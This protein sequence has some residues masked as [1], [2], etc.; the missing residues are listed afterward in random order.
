[1]TIVFLPGQ[2]FHLFLFWPSVAF[3]SSSRP[4][5]RSDPESSTAR[6]TGGLIHHH[7][8]RLRDI[9]IQKSAMHNWQP[10]S[11]RTHERKRGSHESRLWEQ[12]GRKRMEKGGRA[13]ALWLDPVYLAGLH[14]H[15]RPAATER[16]RRRQ[17]HWEDIHVYA[18]GPCRLRCVLGSYVPYLPRLHRCAVDA[19]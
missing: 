1:M 2:S 9:T 8:T 12:A 16:R 4:F 18:C 14:N 3:S 19:R 17:G 13:F 11:S 15:F 7:G 10:I 5:S 6:W